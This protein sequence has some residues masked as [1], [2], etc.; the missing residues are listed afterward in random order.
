MATSGTRHWNYWVDQESRPGYA[1]MAIDQTLLDRVNRSGE[2][3][4]R[5]YTW[6]PHC[7]SFGR[8]EPAARRYD[9]PRIRAMGLDT[10]RRPTGGRAVW[11]SF[12]ITYAVVAPCATFGSLR[13]AYLEI[14]GMLAD[15]LLQLGVEATLASRTSPLPVNAGACFSQPAGGEVLAGGRKVIGSA[16]LRQGGALLQHG[17]ILMRDDQRL[18]DLLSSNESF[19]WEENGG[20]AMGPALLPSSCSAADLI[21]VI[22]RVARARWAGTWHEISTADPL[23]QESARHVAH[24]RSSAWTWE[25]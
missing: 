12:E 8:H 4:L 5:L 3:W 2:H 20:E 10:V 22:G 11:H 23:V 7:L 13:E 15:A 25:R 1:N 18:V 17:S 21:T 24:F 9:V 16:Q 19:S 6:Q 14:H